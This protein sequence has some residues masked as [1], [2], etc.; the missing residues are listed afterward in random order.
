[1][2]VCKGVAE[3]TPRLSPAPPR[4]AVVCAAPTT[5]LTRASAL[6]RTARRECATA[7]CGVRRRASLGRGRAPSPCSSRS[8][9]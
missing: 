2:C 4:L 8:T 9:R 7:V 3:R 5:S 1:M 6:S